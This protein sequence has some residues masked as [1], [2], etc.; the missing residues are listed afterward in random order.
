MRPRTCPYVAQLRLLMRGG[1]P[2]T[3]A[4]GVLVSTLADARDPSRDPSP[5][6]IE[7]LLAAGRRVAREL[8]VDDRITG[9]PSGGEL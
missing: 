2:L 8:G 3:N 4:V 9:L 7:K 1:M 6:E 5:A